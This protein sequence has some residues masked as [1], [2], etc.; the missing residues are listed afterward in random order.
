MQRKSCNKNKYYTQYSILT[1][2]DNFV[3]NYKYTLPP[4]VLLFLL[5]VCHIV[6]FLYENPFFSHT[7]KLRNYCFFH[8]MNTIH[9]AFPG[10]G[11]WNTVFVR[12]IF[13]LFYHTQFS[14]PRKNNLQLLIFYSF[15]FIQSFLPQQTCVYL[16]PV[17]NVSMRSFG[18]KSF[19]LAYKDSG[20]RCPSC[21]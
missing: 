17:V 15:F 11:Q 7:R 19:S 6:L 16:H 1:H 20:P 18:I 13:F 21:I 4:L 2:P 12:S 8:F 9:I 5:F 14:T 3:L 10:S